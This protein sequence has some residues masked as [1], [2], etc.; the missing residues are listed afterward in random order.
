MFLLYINDINKNIISSKLGLF[1][2]DYKTI[3]NNNDSITLQK[4]LS[5]LSDW[6]RIWQM[7][8]NID[9]CIL[10]RFTRSHSPIINDYLLNNQVIQCSDVYKY[11]GLQLNNTLSWNTHITTI[12]NK[13]TRMLNF[14]KRDLSKCSCTT[15]STA[16]T[17]L[18]RPILEYAT[19]VWDPHHA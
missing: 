7:N 10:L 11:L 6:A 9:K 8:F 15:K 13:A 16:Y 17:T 5:T 2:D 19:E 3:Y 18:V 14:I 1:A 4:D 12:V